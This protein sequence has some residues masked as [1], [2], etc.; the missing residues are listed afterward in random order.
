MWTSARGRGKPHADNSGQG[1]GMNKG[2]FEGILYIL[3][4]PKGTYLLLN[5]GKLECK[6]KN[7]FEDDKKPPDKDPCKNFSD[8]FK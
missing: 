5:T 7:N 8:Y 4:T 1:S 2:I 6:T 3:A